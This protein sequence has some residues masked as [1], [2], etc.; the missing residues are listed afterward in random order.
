METRLASLL[1]V[2]VVVLS[3]VLGGSGSAH[4]QRRVEAHI[5]ATPGRLVSEQDAR[6]VE[7]ADLALEAP[8]P[9]DYVLPVGGVILGGAALVGGGLPLVIGLL[10]MPFQLD[11]GPSDGLTNMVVIG[12]LV[13]LAGGVILGVGIAELVGLGRRSRA[14]ARQAQ[15]SSFYVVPTPDGFSAGLAGTF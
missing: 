9:E 11:D 4:A 15:V 12:G 13:A 1:S 14:A 2:L 7:D 6:L 10:V 8:R 3:V 5:V